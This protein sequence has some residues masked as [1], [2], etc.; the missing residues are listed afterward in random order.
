MKKKLFVWI[1]AVLA[2]ILLCG[3]AISLAESELSIEQLQ[4]LLQES[5]TI[6]EIDREVERLSREE[7][8]ITLQLEQAVAEIGLQTERADQLRERAGK[9]LRS[10]YTQDRQ[11]LWLLLFYAD[12][13]SDAL[14]VFQYLQIIAENDRRSLDRYVTAREELLALEA[15]LAQRLDQLDDIKADYLNQRARRQSLQAELDRMLAEAADKEALL[16]EIE[17]LNRSWHD[18]GLPLFQSFLEAMGGALAELPDYVTRHP[19]ALKQERLQV[20]FTVREAELNAFLREK[21]PL[22]HDFSITLTATGIHITGSRDTLS[23]GIE[24]RFELAEHPDPDVHPEPAVRFMLDD[25]QFRDFDLPDTTVAD[26]QRR[27]PMAFTTKQHDMTAFL[28]ITDVT[29]GPET[30]VITM[31][32]DL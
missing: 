9:V 16:A 20:I 31:A 22:F 12:S 7:Q 3:P 5:L 8:Q 29:H 2:A 21:N 30:L 23:I 26:L 18:E 32:F 13:F 11:N 4:L 19:D 15:E 24:G 10:Y 27:F 6:S 28:A 17:A 14:Q 1:P 25:L